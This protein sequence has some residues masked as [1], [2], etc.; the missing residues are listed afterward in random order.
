LLLFAVLF[1]AVDY[2]MAMVKIQ[3]AEHIKNFYLDRARIAG[4][5]SDKDREEIE[6][7]LENIGLKV[8]KIS[9]PVDPVVR[10]LTNYPIVEV[11][12]ETKFKDNPFMLGFFLGKENALEPKF[13]GRVFSEYAGP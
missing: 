1:G 8:T 13:T 12:I 10:D 3:Q 2:W 7:K 4:Y 11:S 6:T 5:L 9:A